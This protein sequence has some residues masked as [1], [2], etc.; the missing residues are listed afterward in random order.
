MNCETHGSLIKNVCGSRSLNMKFT[1]LQSDIYLCQMPKEIIQ[2]IE[3]WKLACDEIK[4]H[5]LGHL[6]SHENVGTLGN[7]YQCSVPENLIKKSYWLPYTLRSASKIYKVHHRSLKIMEW[8]G[9]F[10]SLDV[11]IN[12]SYKGNFNPRHIHAGFLSGVIYLNN[13]DY[14][15]FPKLNYRFKGSKGDMIIFPSTTDHEVHKQ[16]KDYERI[17]FAFNISRF[18]S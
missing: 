8:T 5:K 6:R 10:D 1:Q 4:N 3:E 14:T 16:K 12:Y 17:T 7:A 13:E 11:W 18:Q 15:H 9:H 2:E